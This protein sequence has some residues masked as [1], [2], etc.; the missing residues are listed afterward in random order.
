MPLAAIR[1]VEIGVAGDLEGED[2]HARPVGLAQHDAV[3]VELV[4]ALEIDPPVRGLLDHV[5]PDPPVVVDERL[6][7]IEHAELHEARAQHAGHCHGLFLPSL[8]A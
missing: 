7:Q 3:P 4:G 1:S 2:V 8:S 6:L 5:E